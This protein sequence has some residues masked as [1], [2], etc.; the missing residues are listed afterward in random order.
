MS[1][2]TWIPLV[3]A[4]TVALAT[5]STLYSLVTPSCGA[6]VR[7]QL[8]LA[9]AVAL[10]VVLVMAVVAF[11]ESSLRRGEPASPDSDAADAH[12][13]RRFLA[14]MATAVAA[15]SALV[16]LAMWFALWVLTPCD[17]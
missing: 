4:P 8:H 1:R 2:K 3:L 16:I 10:A 15:L 9:A 6:Q 12:V 13:G 17:L 7:L 11:G 14:N 5:Q